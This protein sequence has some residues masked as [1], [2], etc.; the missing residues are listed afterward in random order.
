MTVNGKILVANL[1]TGSSGTFQ[2]SP[3]AV[4]LLGLD[5]EAGKAKLSSSIGYNGR[6][7]N[8]QGTLKNVTIG[9]ISVDAPDVTF[10]SK[11]TG[12]DRVPWGINIGNVFLK[13]FVVTIDYRSKTITLERP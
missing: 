4:T 5:D 7:E 12:H 3:A 10:F 1:D 11:G 8:H 2:L 13:D 9:G 6:F